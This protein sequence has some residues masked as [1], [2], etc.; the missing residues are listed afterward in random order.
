MRHQKLLEFNHRIKTM[1][2]EIDD[3][4]EKKYGQKY[5]L[6]PNRPK[7]G[8]TSSR[9]MD[10]LFNIGADFTSGYGSRFGRGYVIHTR[11]STMDH[12]PESVKKNIN[13]DIENLV[14]KKL[15][16][17]FPDRILRLEHDGSQLKIIGNFRLGAA[18]T[19]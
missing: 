13:E 14:Q 10:C 9:E 16:M 17:A 8:T 7:C 4:L 18:S 11:L 19:E 2:D 3:V 6:H 12:I 1:F 5:S 15:E